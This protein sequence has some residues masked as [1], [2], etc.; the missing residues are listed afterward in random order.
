MNGYI[1]LKPITLSGVDYAAGDSIPA[2]AV[3]PSRVPA[4]IRTKSIAR[5]NERPAEAQETPQNDANDFGGVNLPIQTENGV[6][7]LPASGEDIVKAVEVMQMNAEDAA[8][9][10]GDI[11]SETTLIIIDA[12]ESRKTVKTAVKARAEELNAAAEGD[13]EDQEG[14]NGADGTGT[15]GDTEDGGDE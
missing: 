7:E 2:D 4:L 3:L 11:E 15:E 14:Q 13:D 5:I 12:C 10:V 8:K 9:A 6:L 1:A